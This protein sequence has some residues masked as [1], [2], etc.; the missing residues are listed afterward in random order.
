MQQ[1]ASNAIQLQA[2]YRTLH[3]QHALAKHLPPVVAVDDGQ[4]ELGSAALE[5]LLGSVR[6]Q[7]EPL[8]LCLYAV[9]QPSCARMS[10]WSARQTGLA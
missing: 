4:A 5:A 6:P 9:Q 7:L 2:Q 3:L 10:A 1:T 8:W